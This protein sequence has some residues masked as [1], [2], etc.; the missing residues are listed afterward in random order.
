LTGIR[1]NNGRVTLNVWQANYDEKNDDFTLTRFTGNGFAALA[2]YVSD[3]P[4]FSDDNFEYDY[5]VGFVFPKFNNG[6]GSGGFTTDIPPEWEDIFG[7]DGDSVSVGPE[8]G[9]PGFGPV[10]PPEIGIAGMWAMDLSREEVFGRL[11]I[12]SY[13]LRL[14]P[15]GHFD[16]VLFEDIFD[17]YTG[18]QINYRIH[19]LLHGS[20]TV[21][22]NTITLYEGGHSHHGTINGEQI[23]IPGFLKYADDS[24]KTAVFRFDGRWGI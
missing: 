16:L 5:M 6:V 17:L 21:S 22:A 10:G 11:E 24:P 19:W 12:K 7:E 4:V 2:L 23:T 20:Y 3:S 8:V 18:D 15:H 14:F 1:V 13:G 9:P